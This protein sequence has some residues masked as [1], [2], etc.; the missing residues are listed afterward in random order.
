MEFHNYLTCYD[1]FKR[2]SG[3]KD[4]PVDFYST[5]LARVLHN[6][7]WKG[8]SFDK[9]TTHNQAILEV[10]WIRDKKP[11][12]NIW[13]AVIPML[14]KLDLHKVKSQD[15]K[16]PLVNMVMRL[17]KEN[18]PISFVFSDKTYYLRCMMVGNL[19]NLDGSLFYSI[20]IDYGEDEIK[21]VDMPV[22]YHWAI[23][24]LDKP[25]D[26]AINEL[27]L[28]PSAAQGVI[29][30]Q[31]F[32]ANSLR[33]ACMIALIGQ[34]PTL[35]SPDVLSSD[36]LDY[37][38]SND[39]KYVDKAHRRGKIGWDIGKEIEVMP[40][41]RRPHLALRHTGEGGKIPKIVPIKGSIVHREK[42]VEMPTGYQEEEKCV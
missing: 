3:S 33:L 30:P 38:R 2:L 15:I 8:T 21:I 10:G 34:D 37:A 13:P 36:R 41:Y 16:F 11:Y 4:T 24:C 12:Y 32:H 29:A 1:F 31:E 22:Y 19:Q 14:M 42:I 40:H 25:L 26:D 17:P 27:K 6:P 20:F 28:D 35:V 23:T 7:K 18:N 9:T 39:Q 5:M